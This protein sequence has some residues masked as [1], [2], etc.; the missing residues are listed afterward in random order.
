MKYRTAARRLILVRAV[1]VCGAAA[2][3]SMALAA[4][5]DAQVFTVTSSGTPSLQ[6]VIGQANSQGGNNTIVLT[7]NTSA[8]YK[9]TAALTVAKGDNLTITGDHSRADIGSI[10][11]QINGG[12]QPSTP[13]ADF[14]TVNSGASLTIEGVMFGQCG[15]TGG[16]QSCI[17]DKG[18]LTMLNDDMAGGNGPAVTVSAGATGAYIQDSTFDSDIV[19]NAII[20]NAPVTLVNDTI[21]NEPQIGLQVQSLGSFVAYNTLFYHN[22]NGNCLGGVA[23]AGTTG[24]ANDGSLSDDGSCGVQYLND[25]SP[26]SQFDA[27]SNNPPTQGDNGGPTLSDAA[28][29]TDGVTLTPIADQAGNGSVCPLVDQR[30]YVNPTGACDIGAVTAAATQETQAN[31]PK[32]G[33]PTVSNNGGVLSQTVPVTSPASGFGPEAGAPGDIVNDGDAIDGVVN[34]GNGLGHGN[35]PGGITNGTVALLNPFTTPGNGTLNVQA[36]KTTA[37]TATEWSFTSTDWAGLSTY[38]S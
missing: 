16:A 35:A 1:A 19:G 7:A 8:A 21:A 23:G 9:P 13:S 17:N 36:T 5:A 28:V 6:T 34:S 33:T 20:A 24:A 3:A 14:L 29:G 11:F 26:D 2:A 25:T 32:C 38:C 30:F 22:T 4:G 15:L 31:A 37:G 27:N 10:T 12:Q 18:S